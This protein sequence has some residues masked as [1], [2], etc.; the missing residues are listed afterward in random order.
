[1]AGEI[2]L[3]VVRRPTY[4]P[5]AYFSA[6]ITSEEKGRDERHVATGLQAH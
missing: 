4:I 2:G 6:L 3:A 5:G 1:M